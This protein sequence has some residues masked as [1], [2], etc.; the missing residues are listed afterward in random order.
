M[1]RFERLEEGSPFLPDAGALYIDSFPEN[2]RR[3]LGAFLREADSF[4]IL[5]D[6]AFAGLAVLLTYGDITHILYLAVAPDRRGRGIGSGALRE[7][8]RR[9]PGQRSAADLEDPGKGA[10][11]AAQRKRRAE[12][13]A[14][15]GYSPT[16]IRYRWRGV[17]Y[18]IWS[19]GG[20][21]TDEE[22]DAFWEHWG[23]RLG[24]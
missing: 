9:Y 13:Y 24:G 21:I 10:G 3:P 17:D 1:I 18:A 19:D 20:D 11:N 12:F 22:L 6:G 15:C 14:R 8:R 4:A 2:E 5:E 16:R 23:P 7:I